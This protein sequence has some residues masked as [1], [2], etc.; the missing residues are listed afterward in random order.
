MFTF[1]QYIKHVLIANY[2][3]HNVHSPFVFNFIN[4]ILSNDG[5]F[6]CFE[7]IESIRKKLLNDNR[8]IE[9]KE[10]GAGSK[11]Y[12]TNKRV[13][14]KIAKTSVISEKEA[15]LL[16]KIANYFQPKNIIELGTSLGISTLY[17]ANVNNTSQVYTVEGDK[18]IYNIANSYFNLLEQN[19]IISYNNNF[20]DKLP[21]ILEKLETVDCVYFDGNHTK[22][23][24]LRY[25]N[26][27]LPKVNTKTVLI[28]DDIYWSK[29][30][31]SAW[32]EIK[33]NNKVKI[34]IDLFCMGIVLFRTEQL[35]E[36]FKLLV[37]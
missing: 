34:T 3:G 17:L 29:D 31:F 6:Y 33:A 10:L 32:T 37:C 35:K 23:A 12:K 21:Q 4:N 15:K 11:V 26:M 8:I 36:D 28:F 14:S 1:F 30:M 9:I 24:T 27:V 25:F 7:E 20:D 22:D 13:I 16:F 5:E 19:N 2:K 18:Q